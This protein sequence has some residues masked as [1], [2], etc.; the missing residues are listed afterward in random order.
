MEGI[1]TVE[2]IDIPQYKYKN[3]KYEILPKLP[4]R[5]I[6]VASSTGGKSVLI[7]N[8]I[9]KIYRGSFERIYIYIFSPSI[10]VDDTWTAVKKYISDVMKV[11]A[12]KEQIYH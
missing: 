10:H 12:E 5:M 11:D 3:S 6:A 7:Q 1:P 9:L 2:S 8:L 4:A